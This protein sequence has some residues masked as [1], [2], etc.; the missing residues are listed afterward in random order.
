MVRKR[1]V[2]FLLA[3]VA[4]AVM[5]SSGEVDAQCSGG[6]G[7]GA[8]PTGSPTSLATSSLYSQNPLASSGYSQGNL[9]AMQYQQRV[10]ATQRQ[11]ASVMYL[12]A[13]RQR[14]AAMQREAQ[15][16]PYRLARAEANR[17]KRAERIAE[18]LREQGRSSEAY[19]LASVNVD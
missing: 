2:L 4:S 11:V 6:G 13:Q 3:G 15:A 18:R 7:R 8:M 12:N 19:T 1:N 17:A 16:L 5:F 14:L 10:L 9:M